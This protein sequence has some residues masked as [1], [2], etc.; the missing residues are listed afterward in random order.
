MWRKQVGLLAAESQW[1]YELVG[2]HFAKNDEPGFNTLGFDAG[3][4]DWHVNQCS[5]GERQRLALLRLLQNRPKVLLLDEP[6]A[7]LD[8]E[9]VRLVEALVKNFCHNHAAAVLW[10][11]HDPQQIQRLADRHLFLE[12][13]TLREQPVN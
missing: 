12:Q 13:G 1:W 4:L 2:D 8:P 11:S 5:T 6:T 10:V 7:S 9:N 3:V